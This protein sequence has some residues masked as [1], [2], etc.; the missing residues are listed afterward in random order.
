MQSEPVQV[1]FYKL[2][3]CRETTYRQTYKK[4]NCNIHRMDKSCTILH[5]TILL[6]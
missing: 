6:Q 3:A 2:S 1:Q 4:N 5:L